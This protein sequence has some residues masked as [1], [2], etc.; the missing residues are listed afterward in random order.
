[1]SLSALAGVGVSPF[2]P[3][4]VPRACDDLIGGSAAVGAFPLAHESDVPARASVIKVISARRQARVRLLVTPLIM[5]YRHACGTSA[6]MLGAVRRPSKVVWRTH[7]TDDL[8]PGRLAEAQAALRRVAT[9]VAR[10]APPA[11]VFEAVAGEVGQL[12]SAD[13]AALS[14]YE[15][16]DSFTTIGF[17]S[18]TDGYVTSV[19]RHALERGTVARLVF[20]TR[21]PGRID[22][23]AD[24]PGSAAAAVRDMGW[25][26]SV[27]APVI[28]A[29]RL[30][31][32]VGVASTSDRS[33]PLE[34]EAHL[35]EFTELLTTA[36]ANAQSR[37]ELTRLADEQAALRR[38]ATLVAHGAPPGSLFAVVA[39]EV[40]RV[41]HVPVVSVVR[42]EPDATATECASYSE[43]GELFPVGTRWSLEGVNV[44]AMVR[45]SG[46]PARINEYSG[47]PG[48]IAENARRAGL[49]STVG[50]PIVV[51]GRVWGTMVVSSTELESL[52]EG[53]EARLA[54][55]TELVATALANME[56]RAEVGRLAEEQ[57]SLRRVATLVARGVPPADVFAAVA[58]EVGRVLGADVTIVYRLDPDGMVTIVARAGEATEETIAMGSRWSIEPHTS[59]ASVAQTGRPGRVDD[60]SQVF[61]HEADAIR[62]LGLRSAVATPVVIE[63]HLWGAILTSRRREALPADTEGRLAGFTEL[64]ATAIAN[65]N[66]RA[67]LTASRVRLVA[68]S[69]ET[70]RR[71]EQDLHDGV[72]Q[73]LVSLSLELRSAEATIPSGYAE[74]ADQLTRIGAGLAG[75][76]DDLRELSRGIH[77]AILS[78]GGLGPALKSLARRSAV[79][80]ALDADVG[81]RLAERVEVAAYYVVSEA[82][83]NAAKHSQ[84]SMTE[85]RVETRGGILDL[86]IRDDGVGGADPARGSGLTGLTDRVEALGGTLAITSP[87]GEG[88]SLH[89][90]LPVEVA[91]RG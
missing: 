87:A 1:M 40:A 89:V 61:G 71:F 88:T 21:R 26:S 23:Y 75:V 14:R 62:R 77:P 65:A 43:Q 42:Y 54:D 36:I 73:R 39:E 17:W 79:P 41:L 33:L 84:A 85:I 56:A 60:L 8:E 51:A 50:I 37:E 64:V 12:V 34:T 6:Q 83:A 9:L 30:W 5:G 46:R 52:P 45:N 70:R 47:L 69:D 29:D 20:E 49:R 22:T 32:L 57:A 3:R 38:V 28:V 48:V 68:A 35:V 86:R 81:M 59:L 82:L 63:G 7:V 11:E 55:F 4:V 24:V 66:S 72:Q 13:A 80:I 58:E 76:L 74:L 27:G 44:V 67:E 53:T 18:R 15:P 90:E 91:P 2:G 78:Q 31:G 19:T 16:D 25:R 10:A